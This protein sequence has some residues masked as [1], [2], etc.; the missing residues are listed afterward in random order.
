MNKKLYN[1]LQ[2]IFEEILKKKLSLEHVKER[3]D[4]VSQRSIDPRVSNNMMMLTTKYQG[5]MS[6][7]KVIHLHIVN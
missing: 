7:A 6:A 4:A 5:L 1:L 2:D 3:G